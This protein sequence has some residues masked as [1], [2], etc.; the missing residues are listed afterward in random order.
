MSAHP[1]LHT[2]HPRDLRH[3]R[4]A[5]H[6]PA[7]GVVID[8]PRQ[9]DRFPR[10]LVDRP[11]L[12][13]R[14]TT[15]RAPL[16]VLSAPAGYGKT[17]VLA[18]WE[19]AD[20]RPFVWI[21]L[22]DRS[23]D[24]VRLAASIVARLHEVEP[25]PEDVVRAGSAAAPDRLER[26]LAAL[27][28]GRRALVLV[29]D[30]AQSLRAPAALETISVIG[31]HLGPTSTV[32]ISSRREPSMP[33][34]RLRA[35]GSVLEL[36]LA[37]LSMTLEEATELLQLAGLDLDGADVTAVVRRTEGWPAALQ[38]AA[39]ALRDRG[40]SA[41]FA[42]DDRVVADYVRREVLEEL[43]RHEQTILVRSSPL[44]RLSS[45]LCDAVLERQGTGKVLR[46]LSRSGVP[47]IP[48]DRCDHEYRLHGLVA[49]ALRSELR[50]VE[51]QVESG[52]HAR[53][54]V[55][56]EQSGELEGAI[57]EAI[58]AADVGR[59]AALVS[60]AAPALALE[61]RITALERWVRA[62]DQG[63]IA[64][65]PALALAAATSRIV[66][67]D[68][69]LA[70]RWIGVA[71][72]AAG[73]APTAGL[74]AAT[75]ALRASIAPD[76]VAP[77]QQDAARA[78]ALSSSDSAWR[79]VACLLEGVGLH[80]TG[81]A[82]RARVKLLEGARLAAATL[83]LARVLCLAQLALLTVDEPDL[84]EA[85]NLAERALQETASAGLSDLPASALAFAISASVFA[86]GGRTD[87]ARAAVSDAVRLRASMSDPP[88]WYDAELRLALA[89]AELR[90]SNAPA[91]ALAARQSVAC[92]TPALRLDRH[93]GLDR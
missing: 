60:T 28:R 9:P 26:L 20:R 13:R 82:A 38:L 90:L 21:A 84:D 73:S 78:Y 37:D 4:R 77:M 32:A 33:L 35:E 81:D 57:D 27:D 17:A 63:D 18:Q 88:P 87:A 8:L 44:E 7:A 64:T 16:A 2:R 48:L 79:A 23:N 30:D 53:A 31:K 11:A 25:L 71:E 19:K 69:D 54:S 75:S 39:Q 67:G 70:E 62:F 41:G 50:R 46:S 52:I 14:L 65:H 5:A 58:A 22:D 47:L 85:L 92:D 29:F 12:V 86:R 91:C 80:L 56:L 6:R 55:W 83:P 42:G 89:D 15:S 76:G 93:A 72:R 66:R 49:E 43:N 51:P 61:G 59:A 34:G 10:P 1:A 24:P 40:S 36:G 45:G 74:A 68:R 3:P